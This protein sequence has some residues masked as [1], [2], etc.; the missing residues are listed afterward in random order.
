MAD[1]T[2]RYRE[3][4]PAVKLKYV[5]AKI[6]PEVTGHVT[7]TYEEHT[8]YPAPGTVFGSV[9]VDAIP[10]PTD[11]KEIDANG[12]HDVRRY[13]T[14]RVN[15]PIPPGYV[16]PSGSLDI[17]E[18]ADGI[19]VTEKARVNVN[20]PIP[21]GYIMPTGTKV[22]T[23]NGTGIDVREFERVDVDVSDKPTKG[24]VYG[25]FD[26]DGCPLSLTTYGYTEIK[27]WFFYRCGYNE[28]NRANFRAK[29]E[30]IYLNEGITTILEYNFRDCIPVKNIYFPSTLVRISGTFQFSGSSN[31]QHID[32]SKCTAVPTLTSTNGFGAQGCTIRVPQSLLA[33]WQ[34]ATNWNALTGVVWEGV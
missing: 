2:L 12:D 25:D 31:L 16:R 29:V 11:V 5:E 17:T 30:N 7:P 32:F 28:Y 10:D 6:K 15:V 9:E 3:T 24:F 27:A 18:N 4:E 22:I 20:V 33:E 8:V 1:F 21:P 26:T 14:A 34:A 23:G 19:D 13:G